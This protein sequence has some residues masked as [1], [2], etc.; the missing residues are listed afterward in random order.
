MR[1]CPKIIIGKRNLPVNTPIWPMRVC[2]VAL[3]LMKIVEERVEMGVD[4]VRDILFDNE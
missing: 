4:D 3:A 2:W 1:P